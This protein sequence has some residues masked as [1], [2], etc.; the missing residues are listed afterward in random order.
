MVLL[1]V[2][3]QRIADGIAP[4]Q[5]YTHL[6]SA[7]LK[8][9]LLLGLKVFY[10]QVDNK[11][12]Y[13]NSI[14]CCLVAGGGNLSR[15]CNITDWLLDLLQLYGVVREDNSFWNMVGKSTASYEIRDNKMFQQ[16]PWIISDGRKKSP[17][18][19]YQDRNVM[20]LIISGV[21]TP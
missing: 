4:D 13:R 6:F 8:F 19:S 20:F 2:M 15:C 14:F 12:P 3:G 5:Y 17:A 16:L 18:Q 9:N 10:L 11:A 1:E 21:N 7:S